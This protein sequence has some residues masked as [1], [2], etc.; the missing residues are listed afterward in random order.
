[1]SYEPIRYLPMAALGTYAPNP[2]LLDKE[3]LRMSVGHAQHVIIA[4]AIT[5]GDARRAE[6]VMREH[7]NAT[8]EYARLFV[9]PR[10]ADHVPTRLQAV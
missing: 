7:S 3:L 6:T 5:D 10:E 9:G 2:D 4:K 8:F 1:M